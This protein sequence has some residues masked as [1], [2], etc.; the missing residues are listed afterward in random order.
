[1]TRFKVVS[2]AKYFISASIIVILI[3]VGFG[4]FNGINLG[5]D[6]TGGT[7]MTIELGQ[8]FDVADINEV[9]VANGIKDAP[10]VKTSEEAGSAMTQAQIRIKNV[11]GVKTEELRTAIL[12]GLQEKYPDAVVFDGETIGGVTS[13]EIITNAILSVVIASALMLV[14]IWI[15]FELFSGIAAVVALVHDILIMSSIM[16]IFHK[17]VN[18]P[19]IAAVLTIVGYSINDTIVLFDRIR[20]NNRIYSHAEYTRAEVADISFNETLSRTLNTSLTTLM[21]ITCVYIF[22]VDSIKEFA[23]PLIVG[24]ISGTY[25]SIFIAAPIWVWLMNRSLKKLGIKQKT[26]VKKA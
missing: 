22:G 11:D 16:I 17:Q 2:K 3:G 14:Y 20:E 5:I 6:F 13:S 9:L 4:L 15:R 12:D 1:M 25:S 24:L 19:Y 8:E 18:S 21:T 7:L 23:F 10:V 26:K